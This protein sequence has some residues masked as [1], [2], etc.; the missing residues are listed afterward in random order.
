V[1]A[2]LDA[3]FHEEMAAEEADGDAGGDGTALIESDA[4]PKK[5]K[6]GGKKGRKKE[7]AKADKK[8][9]AAKKAQLSAGDA[10]AVDFARI[11]YLQNVISEKKDQIS[12][13]RRALQQQQNEIKSETALASANKKILAAN[14]KK[15]QEAQ[16]SLAK[17]VDKYSKDLKKKFAAKDDTPFEGNLAVPEGPENAPKLSEKLAH[18]PWVKESAM[19][20][21]E[22]SDVEDEDDGE[23]DLADEDDEN[24]DDDM[25]VDNDAE[26]PN[27]LP[28]NSMVE[29]MPIAFSMV[30]NAQKEKEH[31]K[32]QEAAVSGAATA[33]AK[34]ELLQ[35]TISVTDEAI[36]KL[37]E[38]QL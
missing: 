36:R 23:D 4:N 5:G 16:A 12:T 2:P 24:N 35:K 17:L 20:I 29:T 13:Q 38:M 33:A 25:V 3:P 18:V 7:G 9:G 19:F 10:V 14:E 27:A 37:K 1:F 6:K 32:Q 11:Q 30:E 8:A 31:T 28:D 21:E 34:A 26:D 15:V 22:H